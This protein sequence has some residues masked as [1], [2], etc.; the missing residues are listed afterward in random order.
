MSEHKPSDTQVVTLIAEKLRDEYLAREMR[1]MRGKPVGPDPR[2][3]TSPFTR[4]DLL[5]TLAAA[6]PVL[7]A[8]TNMLRK[9]DED[10][11][12]RTLAA[13][14]RRRSDDER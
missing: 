5:A 6:P 13:E 4:Q 10:A 2:E 14:I 8:W 9:D 3:I 1:A 12:A 11:F 7:P